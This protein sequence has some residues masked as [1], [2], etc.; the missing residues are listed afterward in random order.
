MAIQGI[1]RVRR[2]LRVAVDNIAGGVSERAVYEVLSQGA[3]KAQT[4]TPIDTSTLVDSQTAPQITVGPNGVEGSV[5]YTAAYAAAVHEAPGTLAGQPRDENDPSRGDYWDPN[6]EPEFLTKGFDQII[7][8][9][10]A[11]LRRTYRV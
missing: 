5:G 3:T 8:A 2:N 10:P 11:I 6:A 1:D 4:M 9:I 7:P